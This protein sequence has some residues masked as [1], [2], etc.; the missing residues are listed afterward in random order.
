[1]LHNIGYY[2]LMARALSMAYLKGPLNRVS[3]TTIEDRNQT[4]HL[5]RFLLSFDAECFNFRGHVRY[6]KQAPQPVTLTSAIVPVVVVDQI[7]AG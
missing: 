4:N 7:S 3:V 5:M 1:M 2:L 6:G